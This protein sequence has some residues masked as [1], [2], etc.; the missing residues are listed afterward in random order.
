MIRTPS[1]RALEL[2]ATLMRTR[3]LTM[4][5][6]C[7]GIS[8]PAASLALKELEAQ[9]GF[10]LFTRERQRMVPTAEAKSLLAEVERLLAQA[11]MVQRQI[12]ALQAGSV[13]AMRVASILSVSGT[14]LPTVISGFQRVQPGVNIQIEVQPYAGVLE[15]VRHEAVELGFINLPEEGGEQ[16]AEPLLTTCLAC[17]MSP[18]HPLAARKSVS[19]GL[20]KR[21][22]TIFTAHGELPPSL[23]RARVGIDSGWGGAGGIEVN[24]VYTA[25]ALAREGIG[26]ALLNPLLLLNA[27]ANG[28]VGRE[29]DAEIPLALAMVAP[30]Q[31]R[32]PAVSDLIEQAH[33]AARHGA[34][35]LRELGVRARAA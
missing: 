5:A 35:R 26:V 18:D 32:M 15:L 17:L 27:Q 12:E 16:N 6:R 9:T 29:L 8:Q 31:A 22:T 30:R 23:L 11:D 21:Y 19:L 24:N 1:L 10:S 14:L 2:F 28:L 3:S 25:I 13:R 4:T 34:S 20:L 33:K 7:I